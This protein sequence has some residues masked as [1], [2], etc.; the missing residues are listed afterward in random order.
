M[1]S[2]KDNLASGYM[3]IKEMKTSSIL[4]IISIRYLSNIPRAFH[5][6]VSYTQRPL[7]KLPVVLQNNFVIFQSYYIFQDFLVFYGKLQGK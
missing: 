3:Y 6:M 7:W 5:I 2:N 4:P 1:S